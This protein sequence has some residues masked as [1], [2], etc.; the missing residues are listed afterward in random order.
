MEDEQR[1]QRTKESDSDEEEEEDQHQERLPL[2]AQ[3]QQVI[4]RAQVSQG[5]RRRLAGVFTPSGALQV[6]G[7]GQVR[8]G[9][10]KKIRVRKW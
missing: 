6:S 3:S 5:E 4:S 8:A 2:S 9:N 1:R 7:D 10:R